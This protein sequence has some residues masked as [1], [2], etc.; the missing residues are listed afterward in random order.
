M[1]LIKY[2][3]PDGLYSFCQCGQNTDVQ[4]V[5]LIEPINFDDPLKTKT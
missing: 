3:G 5:V 4:M 1:T 2:N